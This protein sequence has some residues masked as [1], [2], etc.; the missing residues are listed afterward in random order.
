MINKAIF[1]L[2]I[3]LHLP[4]VFFSQTIDRIEPPNWWIGMKD[5]RLQIMLYGDSLGDLRAESTYKGIKILKSE[6][7]EN[8][9]YL[10]IDLEIKSKAK[11]GKVPIKLFKDKKEIT[12]IEYSLLTRVN[13]SASRKGYNTEDVIYLITPD[14]FANG[15]PENDQ[16]HG[17]KENPDRALKNGRH[18]GD[19]EGIRQNLD[20]ISKMGFTAIWSNPVLENDMPK[21]SYHGYAITD[22]YKVDPRMG[23]NA[24]YKDFCQEAN[25]KGIKIIMDMILNHTGSSHWWMTNPPTK[26][27]FNY[28]NQPYTETN[29]RKTIQ[30]DPYSAA[31]DLAILEDGWF[32]PTMPDMNVRN[33][34]LANYLIENTIWWIEYAG[35]SGIRMDTY[36]Y[37]DEDFMA[38]WSR[39]VMEE[40]PNFNITGEVWYENPSIVS[41]WQKGKQNSNGYVSYLP[42]LFD[43]PIQ[44]ALQK[45]LL[46]PEDRDGGWLHLYEMLALDFQYANPM[47]LVVFPDNHDMT[48]IYTQLGEDQAKLKM[49]LA[50]TLTIRG[51][52][53]IFYGTEVLMTSPPQRDDGLVRSDFPGGWIGDD[54]NAFSGQ[55]LSTEQTDTQ[56][57]LRRILTW[58]KGAT[59]IHHGQITHF[60]PQQGVYVFFRYDDH[61][62]VMIILNKNVNI[63]TLKLDRFKRILGDSITGT[64]II[65]GKTIDLNNEILLSGPGPMIVEIK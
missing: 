32:V 20:Y 33:P 37:P 13:G 53:Q 48:R 19:I 31:E 12:Q 4:C 8:K 56:E 63:T 55:G 29:H 43:F 58:R 39:R 47:Q 23:T 52:P 54:K 36:F 35:L 17:M 21:Y 38:E 30:A 62:K 46:A 61:Q 41:Y 42:S 7:P 26:D 11:P 2:V 40:Y 50:Y 18:G 27:W 5:Q 10:F 57:F 22:F 14:R 16:I 6:S 28:Y 59:A 3:N 49:A 15:D 24:S 44:S 64:E 60:V 1:C 45:A 51:I 34:W 25:Q 65:S 9:S